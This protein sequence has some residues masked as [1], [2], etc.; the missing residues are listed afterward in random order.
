MALGQVLYALLTGDLP[1]DEPMAPPAAPR[2]KGRVYTPRRS[3]WSPR[4]AG[5]GVAAHALPASAAGRRTTGAHPGRAGHGAALGVAASVPFVA[6][7]YAPTGPRHTRT[8][9]GRAGVRHR[10]TLLRP[11]A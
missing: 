1:G 4:R 7:P 3:G 8:G 6:C 10:T 2:H 11:A 5:D 9:P